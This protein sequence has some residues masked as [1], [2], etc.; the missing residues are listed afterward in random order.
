[1]GFASKYHV[2]GEQ[3]ETGIQQTCPGLMAVGSGGIG[4]Y[5]IIVFCLL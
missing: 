5:N 1:M 3:I 2:S 4:T